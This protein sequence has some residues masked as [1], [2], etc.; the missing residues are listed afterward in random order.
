VTIRE[1][2]V[3]YL[4]QHGYDGLCKDSCGCG[5]DDLAPC[6]GDP[7]DCQPAH[8]RKCDCENCDS[9]CDAA[10]EGEWCYGTTKDDDWDQDDQRH[11][12][13]MAKWLR[14][15]TEGAKGMVC[16]ACGAAFDHSDGG[17]RFNGIG[18]EHSHGQAGH[19]V[20]VRKDSSTIEA[21]IAALER[22]VR[23]ALAESKCG[24][25]RSSQHLIDAENERVLQ[26]FVGLCATDP[27]CP[28]WTDGAC[29][30]FGGCYKEA[31][32]R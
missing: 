17:W 28:H 4:R 1:I 9:A 18:W 11:L 16:S 15:A 32:S 5:L 29:R 8:K 20:A 19:F 30:H 21:R 2:I 27:D 12:D 6:G 24:N 7:M 23:P 13:A 14:D 10:G 31:D 22:A 25:D 3:E 26:K